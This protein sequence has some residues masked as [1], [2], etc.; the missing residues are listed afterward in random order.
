MEFKTLKNRQL[1]IIV[2][3]WTNVCRFVLAGVFIF[4][5]F[6]KAIDPLGTTYKI[7]DY[8]EALNFIPLISTVIPFGGALFIAFVEFCLGVFLLFGFRRRVSTSFVFV[9]MIIMTLLTFWLAIMN[10]ISDCGCFGDAIKL[11]NWQTF[12]KNVFLLIAAVSVFR[13]GNQIRPLVSQRFD[14]LIELYTFLFIGGVMVY[15]LR[16]LPVFDFRPYHIG[17]NIKEGMEIPEGAFPTE[18]E[19]FF[20]LEKDGKKKEFTLDNYPDSTW[21]FVDSRTVVKKRGY[22]PPI[23]DFSIV[24]H[25]DGDD[26][27]EAVLNNV[28]YSFLLIAHQLKEADDSRVDLINELYDYCIENGYA[29]YCLTAS[30]DEDIQYWQER[31]GAEYPFA[32]T[33]DTTLR[34]IIRSNPGLVLLKKG[35]VINKWSVENIPDEYQLT[36]KLEKLSLGHINQRGP[37]HRILLVLG[38]FVLPLFLFSVIDIVWGKYR[39][40]RKK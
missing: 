1:D 38:W 39:N 16:N 26:I 4:S 10:P 23:H 25:D 18:Y 29:F 37:V 36:D 27:T 31:T 17:A 35:V 11:T 14:W 24:R 21:T 19:T 40:Y 22:E 15:S 32:I 7:Q 3:L 2:S 30:P 12:F 5:G 20:V 33:D 13:W 6:V 28:S 9:F 8:F 34:T